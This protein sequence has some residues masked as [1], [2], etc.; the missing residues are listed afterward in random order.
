[1]IKITELKKSYKNNKVLNGINI[2]FESKGIDIIVG[3][4]G[5][6]KTTLLNCICDIT[7]FEE[8]SVEIDLMDRKEK[9]AK[10]QM[11]YIPSDFYLPEYLSGKE[12]SNFV[13]SRYSNHNSALFNFIIRL[14]NLSSSLDKKV[15]DYSYGM[16]KK[17]QIAIALALDV[18]YV[19]ADEVFNG[20]DYESYLLTD[21][22]INKFSYG[23]KFILISHNMDYIHR[24]PKANVYLLSTG[25]IELVQDIEKI[26]EIV[27]K[28]GELKHYYEEIDRFLRGNKNF[29]E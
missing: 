21:Y 29:I 23:R 26:E 2:Q 24:N 19:L 11:Y 25:Q 15:S 4:N 17:L 18:N 14:Y 3:I 10:R 12:F 9:E 16:K 1:M 27:T 13:F 28:N 22:L 5:C 8:G 6:G 20:L 7:H